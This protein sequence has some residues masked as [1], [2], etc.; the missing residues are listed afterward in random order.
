M[1][2]RFISRIDEVE[3]SI[4]ALGALPRTARRG[5]VSWLSFARLDRHCES[6]G[7]LLQ[8]PQGMAMYWF[9]VRIFRMLISLDV[10]S[11]TAL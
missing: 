4:L 2:Q 11:V 1:E 10:D 6:Y 8:F 3:F 7:V 5:L 9:D